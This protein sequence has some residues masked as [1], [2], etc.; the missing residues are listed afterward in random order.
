MVNRRDKK[1]RRC[2]TVNFRDKRVRLHRR[3]GCLDMTGQIRQMMVRSF[4]TKV[5][6]QT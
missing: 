5:V 1:V 3:R 4:G 2:R 6:Q